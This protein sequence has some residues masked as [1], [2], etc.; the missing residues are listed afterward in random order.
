MSAYHKIKCTET[1]LKEFRQKTVSFLDSMGIKPHAIKAFKNYNGEIR[2]YKAKQAQRFR[3]RMGRILV[4]FKNPNGS[5]EGRDEEEIEMLKNKKGDQLWETTNAPIPCA[6][7]TQVFRNDPWE[8]EKKA[9][10]DFF[11][12][13]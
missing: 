5:Y 9:I 6:N 3:L 1:E 13:D 7:Y 8:E 11:K 10:I 12:G 4:A 2:L